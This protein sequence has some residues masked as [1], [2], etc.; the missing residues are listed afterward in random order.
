MG[1]ANIWYFAEECESHQHLDLGAKVKGVNS[2]SGEKQ[3]EFEIIYPNLIC[4]AL[5][6]KNIE[7]SYSLC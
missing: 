5:T 4:T 6:N 2:L 1:G 7:M 3:H